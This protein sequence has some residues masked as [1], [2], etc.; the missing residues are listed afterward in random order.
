MALLFLFAL[1]LSISV[2]ASAQTTSAREVLSFLMTTQRVATSDF[3]RDQQA[4]EATRDTIARALLVELATLPVAT[5]SPA[6][7][8]R[9]NPDIGTVERVTQSFGPLFV[10][11]VTTSGRGQASM[12]ATYRQ[13]DFI[14]LD[15][16]DLGNASLVTTANKF[17]DEPAPFD[18]EVLSLQLQTRTVTFSGNY[19]ITNAIDIGVAI[20]VMNVTL[21]GERV[22]TYRGT[23]VLQATG[24][25]T[26]T[27]F[28]D[29]ALGTKLQLWRK[30]RAAAG[31]NVELRLPTGSTAN[32]RGAGRAA[33][34]PAVI[35]SAGTNA[36]EGHANVG[37]VVGGLSRE[38]VAAGAL[39]TA[40]AD[41]VTFSVEGLVRRASELSG[42]REVSQP[43]PTFIGVDTIRLLPGTD[44]TTTATFVAGVRWNVTGTWLVNTYVLIPL[45]D[46]GLRSRVMPAVSVE[47]AIIP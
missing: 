17:R 21:S 11:R 22:N 23:S 39:T 31:A 2:P 43:H 3:V 34:R 36:V 46:R 19:G 7:T 38:F 40:L 37:F 9:F 35:V 5:S 16:R 28:G 29:I 10:N 26:T 6:F 1:A 32:L 12:S 15:G 30:G 24:S 42:V 44:A 4:A 13:S 25:A 18:V 45:V 14:R 27:G 20:P 41:R 8:Y 33:L 47:Y